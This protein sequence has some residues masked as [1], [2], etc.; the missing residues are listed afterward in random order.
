MMNCFTP[1][2]NIVHCYLQQFPASATTLH[3]EYYEELDETKAEKKVRLLYVI[4]SARVMLDFEVLSGKTNE[5]N[6]IPD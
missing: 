4:C 2:C 5:Q 6:L 3:F 1:W